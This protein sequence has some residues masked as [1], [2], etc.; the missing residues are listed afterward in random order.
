MYVIEINKYCFLVERR[1][2]ETKEKSKIET[3]SIFNSD[4]EDEEIR[5]K[6]V[7]TRSSVKRK[8]DEDSSEVN[9]VKSKEIC[10][11][12]SE[13][14]AQLDESINKEMKRKQNINRAE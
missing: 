9:E 10:F 3:K 1:L 14:L 5:S 6:P 13:L 4:E 12:A 8:K 11:N 7:N 2:S